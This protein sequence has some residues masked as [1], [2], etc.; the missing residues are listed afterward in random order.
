MP[1]T[2]AGLAKNDIAERLTAA[3]QLVDLQSK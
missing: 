1:A 2:D 3:A